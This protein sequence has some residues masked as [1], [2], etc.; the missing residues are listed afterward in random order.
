MVTKPIWNHRFW[1]LRVWKLL[2]PFSVDV[3]S[4]VV[5]LLCCEKTQISSNSLILNPFNVFGFTDERLPC[6]SAPSDT[7]QQISFSAF[8]SIINANVFFSLSFTAAQE[9]THW[10]LL[11]ILRI[12]LWGN[13]L[14]MA[15]HGNAAA[16]QFCW[17]SERQVTKKGSTPWC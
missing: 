8:P 17:C 6:H 9:S 2:W 7:V 5:L 16:S 11:C 13:F 10:S 12:Y 1:F 4:C 15:F 14:S 3:A